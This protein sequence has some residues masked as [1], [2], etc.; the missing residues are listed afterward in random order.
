MHIKKYDFDYS[1]RHFMEKTALGLGG[2][3]VLTSLWPEI[4]KSGDVSKVYPEELWNIELYTKAEAKL[5]KDTNGD[6]I[7]DPVDMFPAVVFVVAE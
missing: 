2:A 1:R 6:G 7:K 3:G 5:G 4:C